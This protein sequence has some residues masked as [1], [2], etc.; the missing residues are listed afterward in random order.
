MH[1]ALAMRGIES[2]R[3]LHGIFQQ[4]IERYCAGLQAVL[5]R[6]AAQHFHHD[7]MLS[8]ILRDFVN[9]AD[10]G[11]IQRRR[12]ARLA[13]ESLERLRIMGEVFRQKLERDMASEV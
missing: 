9:G 5:Q 3:Q 7:E 2:I 6:L 12:G 10:I 11:M 4:L 1:D 13:A 8:T